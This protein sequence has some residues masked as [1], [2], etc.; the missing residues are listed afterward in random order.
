VT[1]IGLR[2]IRRAEQLRLLRGRGEYKNAYKIMF[3][4]SAQQ[5]RPRRKTRRIEQDNIKRDLR[6]V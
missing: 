4:E 1:G 5:K 6:K 2:T 3:V